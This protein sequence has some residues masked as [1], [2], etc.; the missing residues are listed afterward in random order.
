MRWLT[1]ILLL[2]SVVSFP[3]VSLFSADDRAPILSLD[4]RTFGYLPPVAERD[5][6][7]Y[8]FLRGA[9]TFLDDQTLAVS[10]FK[11]NEHPGLSRRDGT[12]GSEVVFHTVF[13][14]PSTGRVRDQRTWGNA[15]N[16][17][18]LQAFHDGSFFV[19][20]GEW[21]RLYS[22]EL[23][24]VLKKNMDVPGDIPARF[25]VSPSGRAV[26]EFQEALDAKR[27]WLTR[28]DVLDPA[29]LA[30]KKLKVT[31]GH[32]DETVSD[33]EVVYSLAGAFEVPLRLFVYRADDSAPPKSPRLF[34]QTSGM[35]E[36]I[37]ESRCKSAAFVSNS[38]MAVTGDCS[39]LMLITA[40]RKIA[41]LYAPEYRF[42]GEVQP[43]RDGRRFAFARAKA[44]DSPTHVKNMEL[45]VYDLTDKKIVFSLPVSP[46]PQ[47]KL[48]FALSPDG[49]LLAS[50]TDGLLYVWHL[51]FP[52]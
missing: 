7:Y 21:V 43:S 24:E 18:T 12:P 47:H 44:E 40:G 10:F 28:I 52:H 46:L 20:D 14:D 22:N 8:S 36:D 35:A 3:V 9:D 4:L 38:V 33:T 48:A 37:A 19:Q 27:G 6:R 50:Q 41:D 2:S 1:R 31:P 29:S 32:R 5:L 42:G 39:H 16:S 11:K 13:L 15:G 25:T 49:S 30:S 26:Y 17:T 45:C 34:E 51:S 23:Q